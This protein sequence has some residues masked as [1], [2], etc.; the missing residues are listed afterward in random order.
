MACGAAVV[1]SAVGGIPEIVLEGETGLLVPLELDP[2]PERAP[3]DPAAFA[4]ALSGAVNRLV[5]D[6]DL[7]AAMGEAGRR[8]VEARFSWP[9]IA[10]ATLACY[11]RVLGR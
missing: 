5:A 4:T 11:E 3:A 8:R 1:A 6:P 10:A 9:A 7:A 2:G